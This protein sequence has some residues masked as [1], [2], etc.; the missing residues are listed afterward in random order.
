M[1]EN[2]EVFKCPNCSVSLAITY[3]GWYPTG[4]RMTEHPTL[5]VKIR[6]ILAP[7]IWKADVT[8]TEAKRAESR[9]V[10]ALEQLFEDMKREGKR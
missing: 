8:Y 5:A 10:S 6:D 2:E 9:L 4:L 1:T 7:A 3:C